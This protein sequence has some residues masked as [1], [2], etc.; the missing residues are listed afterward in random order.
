MSTINVFLT[1]FVNALVIVI[2]FEILRRRGN[3]VNEDI[4]NKKV[5]NAPYITQNCCSWWPISHL[6]A[7]TIYS[8][9]WPQ[10]SVLLFSL[11]V[12]WEL[13][14]SIINWWETEKGEVVKH[15]RTRNKQGDV[16]YTK[17]WSGSMKDIGFNSVGIVLG[18]I[19]SVT[20]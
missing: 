20:M 19:L 17:W 11:G 10:H 8:F 2:Y 6:I 12:L 4:M 1:L 5:I 16:E 13:I 7:F 18:R 9:I 15:Q 3:V 14:E